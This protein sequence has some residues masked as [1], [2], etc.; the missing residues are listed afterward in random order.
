MDKAFAIGVIFIGEMV[1]IF[2]EVIAAK[3]ATG[4]GI[5]LIIILEPIINYTIFHELPSKGATVGMI[6]GFAGL[7]VALY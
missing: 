4:T 3:L 5:T 2:A 1:T 6:L 7:I